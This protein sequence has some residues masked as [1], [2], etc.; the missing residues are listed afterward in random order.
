MRLR[1]IC[2]FCILTHF[3]EAQGISLSTLNTGGGGIKL[4]SGIQID[5]SVGEGSSVQTFLGSSGIALKSGILQPFTSSADLLAFSGNT[6][7]LV[8]E[9]ISYPVPF[10]HV[11]QVDIKIPESGKIDLRVMDGN[12][13]TFT[14]RS[15]GYN[16][17]NGAQKFDLSALPS[18][19]YYLEAILSHPA[20]S[21]VQRKGTFKL[22]KQ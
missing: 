12:G 18:G 20:I 14:S 2:F 8:G 9:I 10:Q 17:T 6:K 16:K 21:V 11:L 13:R 5:W 3:T 1:L 15:F 7:W 19:T 4:N 22:I